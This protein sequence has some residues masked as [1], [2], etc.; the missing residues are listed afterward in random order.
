MQPGVQPLEPAAQ[1]DVR[2]VLP[3]EAEEPR[4]EV[5]DPADAALAAAVRRVRAGV[6]EDALPEAA[7][8]GWAG[9]PVVVVPDAQQAVPDALQVDEVAE[10][11]ARRVVPGALAAVRASRRAWAVLPLPAALVPAGSATDPREREPHSS[12]PLKLQLR[13]R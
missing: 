8:A 9:L 6:V 7:L 5:C 3:R 13:R 12:C 4:A 10:R 2:Q 1:P 11:A